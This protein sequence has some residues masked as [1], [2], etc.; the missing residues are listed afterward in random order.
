MNIKLLT[1]A[2]ELR[3]ISQS[4]LSNKI[5]INQSSLSKFEKGLS[6]L[7]ENVKF[8]IADTLGFPYSFFLRENVKVPISDFYYRKRASVLKK[9]LSKFEAL[10][11]IYRMQI[12]TLLTSVEIP[13][14]DLPNFDIKHNGTPEEIARK[15]RTHFQLEKGPIN[16]LTGLLESHG[17]I[18]IEFDLQDLKIDGISLFTNK[19]QPIIF[20]NNNI[21][22]DR[23]QFTLAHELGHL[24]LHIN[25][26]VSIDRDE[27]DEANKF[28]AEF[29]MPELD[30]FNSLTQL[31]FS[32]LPDLKRY[33]NLSMAFII[34]RAKTLKTITPRRTKN[35]MIELSKRGYRKKEPIITE[36]QSPR[37]LDAIVNVY[38]NELEYTKEEFLEILTFN[39]ID[40]NAFFERR[41][42]NVIK[43]KL[44]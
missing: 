4:E 39:E 18:I 22:N 10:I 21:P 3:G 12:D 7:S 17:L 37:V 27:E 28:A 9:E 1:T 25:S 38:L 36:F 11:D 41:K 29:L 16:D 6:N 8:K 13:E 19:N 5:G 23:K 42:S 32:D 30:C 15:L 34:M 20:L 43:L 31:R 2:R 40:F 44:L 35:L 24:V 33:W 14:Y 26:I